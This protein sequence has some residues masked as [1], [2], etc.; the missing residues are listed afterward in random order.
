MIRLFGFGRA[1]AICVGFTF[2]LI[3]CKEEQQ[4]AETQESLH[5]KAMDSLEQ[6]YRMELTDAAAHLDSLAAADEVAEAQRHYQIARRLFKQAEPVL[7]FQDQNNYASLNAPNILK[8]EEEAPTD[9]KIKQPLGFQ[10]IEENLYTESPEMSAVSK[11]AEKTAARLRLVE[12][13]TDMNHYKPYHILWLVRQQLVRTA[14]TG[15]TGFDSPVLEQSLDEAVIAFAKAKKIL[16]RYDQSYRDSSLVSEWN[17]RW[18]KAETFLNQSN[19][20]SFDHFSFIQSHIDPMM[21][22]WTRTVDDWQVEFPFELAMANDATQIF[23][24]RFLKLDH[25]ADR[26][27]ELTPAKIE[28]GKKL[29]YDQRLSSGG[30]MAC[31]TCHLPELAFT[32]GRVTPPGLERNSPTLNYAA[33]QQGFFYDRRAGSLEGQ[34]VS[35]V[36]NEKEFHTDLD[37]FAQRVESDSSYVKDFDEAYKTTVSD[38]AVRQAIAD[39]VRTLNPWNSRFDQNIRGE[40]ND[41][42][43]EERLGFNLFMG[44]AKCATCHFAPIFNGTVPPN[45]TESEMEHLG[46]PEQVAWEDATIDD[47]L[48]RFNVFQTENRKHFFKTPTVRNAALT[49]PYMHNGVFTDLDQLLKFYNVGGGAG[50]GID[51]EFQTL[52][53]DNLELTDEELD[54][55]KA[56]LNSLTDKVANENY[57]LR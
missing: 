44:K 48:G 5:V 34:I 37:Q 33:Y 29:F 2:L 25:F 13:T 19:Y 20:E 3:A 21:E 10:V 14:L 23:S 12:N 51:S 41:L 18:E 15:T 50:I 53:P 43:A 17:D 47:D 16:S 28:L 1:C 11:V 52:P 6:E 27:L 9:I 7:S 32:D 40:R 4:Y 36:V 57:A 35:V 54:A 38:A 49:A 46:T 45:F 42:T 31:A 39:Y 22:L 24:E 8:V 55:L 30:N 56:F 26:S